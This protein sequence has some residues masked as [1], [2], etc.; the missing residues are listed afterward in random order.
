[1]FEK[2]DLDQVLKKGSLLILEHGA[3]SDFG[4]TGPLRLL[5]DYTKREL[6]DGFVAQCEVGA[7]TFDFIGWL[8]SSGKVEDA[9][10]ETWFI[11]EPGYGF[12]EYC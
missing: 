10:A 8:V 9:P 1:M 7:S 5:G 12:G 11:G 3:Y 6:V 2:Q 4:Y